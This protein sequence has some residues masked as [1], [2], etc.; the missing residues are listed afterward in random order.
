MNPSTE[1]GRNRLLNRLAP[2]DYERLLSQAQLVSLASNQVLY[3]ARQPIEFIYFPLNCALSAIAVADNGDGIE[4][5]TIGNEGMAG[6]TAFIQPCVSPNRLLVQIAG[7][8]VRI[9]AK[10]VAAECKIDAALNDLLLQ[11]HSAFLTQMTQSIA[12]NGLH[13]IVKRCCRWLL[14]THD[15]IDGDELRLTHAFLSFM[16][17][18]RRPTVTE[19]LQLLQDQGLIETSR[20]AIK[21]VNRA[22]LEEASCECYQIVAAEYRRLLG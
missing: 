18:A 13:P 1:W 8:A 17:A 2:K 21:I 22:G 12:C 3:E 6:L 19:N 15:R 7:D 9:D 11:H 10:A 14:M 4:V 16:L 20:G 5:G